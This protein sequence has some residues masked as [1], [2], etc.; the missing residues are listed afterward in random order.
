MRA[1]AGF[2]KYRCARQNGKWPAVDTVERRFRGMME[3]L[4]R[5]KKWPELH[6]IAPAAAQVVKRNGR[7]SGRFERFARMGSDISCPTGDQYVYHSV[8]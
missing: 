8:A 2:Q 1:D 5:R 4:Y 3:N 7:V 6:C